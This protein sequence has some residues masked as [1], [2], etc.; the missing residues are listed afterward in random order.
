MN[1]RSDFLGWVTVDIEGG[2]VRYQYGSTCYIG[3][4]STIHVVEYILYILVFINLD[5]KPTI[6]QIL[7]PPM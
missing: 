5:S 3:S 1:T 2:H 7:Q 4:L 6:L